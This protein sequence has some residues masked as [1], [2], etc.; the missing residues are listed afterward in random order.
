MRVG[1]HQRLLEDRFAHV[2]P[3]GQAQ[4]VLGNRPLAVLLE[5]QCT[6]S[7]ILMWPAGTGHARVSLTLWYR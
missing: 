1:E 7:G 3:V 2:G 5:Q 4:V 6:E